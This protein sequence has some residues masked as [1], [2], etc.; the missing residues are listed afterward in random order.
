M[1]ILH[2][3]HVS[4]HLRTLF[5]AWHKD[6]TYRQRRGLHPIL[7]LRRLANNL[8]SRVM[9]AI[10]R[11]IVISAGVIALLLVCVLHVIVAVAWYIVPLL[12]II[13]GILIIAVATPVAIGVAG[14]LLLLTAAIPMGA[15]MVYTRSQIPDY[16]AMSLRELHKQ[17]WFTRVYDRIGVDRADITDEILDDFTK[18]A[19]LLDQ[20]TISMEEFD[21]IL[22]WEIEKQQERWATRRWWTWDRLRRIRPF[23][24][25][26]VYGY[27]V[28]LDRYALDLSHYMPRQYAQAHFIGRRNA[29]DLLTV[30][31]K[32]R[33]DNNAMIIGD[34]GVGKRTLL[35]DLAQRVRQ[36][37]FDHDSAMR[38]KRFL[39]VDLAAAL[40][41]AQ[42]AEGGIDLFLH[43]I[44][45][46]AAY[47][48][49]VVL[50]LENFHHYIADAKASYDITPIISDYLNLPTFQIVALVPRKVYTRTLSQ[51]SDV[52]QYF[53]P[54]TVEEASPEEAITAL[55]QI[56]S[57][58]ERSSVLFSYAALRDIVQLSGRYRA[59]APLPERAVDLAAE[60]A[61]Y[62]RT[63]Q[64]SVVTPRI[65]REFLTQ[66]TGMPMGRISDAERTRLLNM[67]QLLHER[68]VGQEEAVREVA[69]AVR[70]MRSGIADTKKP[71]S[72]FLFLGPTG[73]GKTEM[74]KTLAEVYYGSQEKMVRIDMS[75]FQGPDAYRLLLGDEETG[76]QGR[77][78]TAAR[79]HP[80]TLLLLDELEK[81]HPRALDLF[82]QILDE[83]F[84]TDAFGDKL[85]FRNMVI[86]ATSNAGA[87]TLRDLIA[88]QLS[89]DVIKERLIDTIVREGI[90]RPEFLNRFNEVIV[91]RPLTEEEM[92]KVAT[93]MINALVERIAREKHITVSIDSEAVPLIVKQS[94]NEAFGARATARYIDDT[95]ADVIARKIIADGVMPGE[96]VSV[97]VKDILAAA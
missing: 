73:V 40:A 15:V 19:K 54:V 25:Y 48:G 22:S 52:M 90:Y 75:E 36:G 78:T 56:Y 53:T 8:F 67:E 24:Q 39:L 69:E 30:T 16:R 84:V 93:L 10:V 18:F 68:L 66:K 42:H 55:L 47:A 60:V 23:G 58:A 97:T 3:F 65:V 76:Q 94:Y 12:P 33:R 29:R 1:F 6:V 96:T 71:M 45:H 89:P 72:S 7:F 26:W 70:I 44:F 74:A 14:M 2:V 81:A 59:D 9:G 83:G 79:E 88:Q 46:E 41:D 91:F 31:L 13:A 49:N 11:L 37:D 85:N 43:N 28:H 51:R 87:T 64:A 77:L 32:R 63:Q 82:L 86:I 35:Y 50:V 21:A 61:L 17:P 27:T 57:E 34:A 95:V 5:S 4:W 62:Y 92:I 80:Y 20:H 38:D